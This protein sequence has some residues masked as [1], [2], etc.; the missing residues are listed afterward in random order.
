M[1]SIASLES[2]IMQVKKGSLVWINDKTLFITND[3]DYD[4]IKDSNRTTIP[5]LRSCVSCFAISDVGVVKLMFYSFRPYSPIR[6]YIYAET[7]PTI[8]SRILDFGCAFV[9]QKLDRLG[10]DSNEDK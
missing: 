3:A 5:Y 7:E 2:A 6:A 10:G 8:E 1:N 4:V 9:M